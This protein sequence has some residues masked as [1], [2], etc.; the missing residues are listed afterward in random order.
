MGSVAPKARVRYTCVGDSLWRAHRSI[1]MPTNLPPEATEAER[2]YR[3]ATAIADKIACLQEFLSLI[4]KHK[5]TDKLRGDLRKRLSKLQAEAQSSKGRSRTESAYRI[6]REG[7]G[8]VVVIGAPNVGKSALVG[9]LTSA[10]PEVS[11]APYTTWEP[12]PGMMPVEDIQVQLIDTPPLNPD[13]VENE[14]MD[15]IRRADL[16]LL[17]VDLQAE[18]LTQLEEAVALLEEHRI[19]PAH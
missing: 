12:M 3:E 2:R 19:V 5:G 13:Y 15:L 17:M 7:A 14:L 11:E 9:A 16:V 10:S 6:D 8:Q 4:P 1:A 18:P